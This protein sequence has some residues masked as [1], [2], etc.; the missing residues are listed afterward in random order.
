MTDRYRLDRDGLRRWLAGHDLAEALDLL[1]RRA[2]GLPPNVVETLQSWD[3]A[4]RQIVLT[5]G[6][7]V[8]D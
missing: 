2:P 5:R 1:R 8:E 4:A 6:Q 7:L 3:R